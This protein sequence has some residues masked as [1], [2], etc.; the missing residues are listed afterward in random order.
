MLYSCT[1]KEIME[2]RYTTSSSMRMG[3]SKRDST[4]LMKA[5]RSKRV[6]RNIIPIQFK[7]IPFSLIHLLKMMANEN[8]NRRKRER[9]WKRYRMYAQEKQT[10]WWLAAKSVNTAKARAMQHPTGECAL[11]SLLLC[12]EQPSKPIS[13]FIIYAQLMYSM[14]QNRTEQSRRVHGNICV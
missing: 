2:Y 12:S 5:I 6:L 1:H 3:Y 4:S 9:K 13:R 8:R 10:A 14:E 11:R 7:L